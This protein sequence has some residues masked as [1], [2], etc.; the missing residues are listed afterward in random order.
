[1]PKHKMDHNK[2]YFET[3]YGNDFQVPDPT[4]KTE[5]CVCV[6]VADS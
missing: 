5:V 4:I 2:H 1:M 3:T 6:C